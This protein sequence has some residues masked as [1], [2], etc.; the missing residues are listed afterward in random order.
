MERVT[1]KSGGRNS[2]G[3]KVY[4]DDPN[5]VTAR[6]EFGCYCWM[7]QVSLPGVSQHQ[8]HTTATA[9]TTNSPV[10]PPQ[11]PG[12]DPGFGANDDF[13]TLADDTEMHTPMP[14]DKVATTTDADTLVEPVTTS[15]D[16]L[17][18][19][20]RL[21]FCELHCITD[22]DLAQALFYDSPIT[23][24]A[25][26]GGMATNV[27]DRVLCASEQLIDLIRALCTTRPVP[28]ASSSQY[29]GP[30]LE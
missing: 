20:Y 22:R 9:I 16:Q 8:I 18:Q 12:S 4:V 26:T 27:I 21:L 2:P 13:I 30:N 29:S 15:R 14:T 23:P 11:H 17:L 3:K 24:R 1:G 5:I 19:I 7:E 28:S 25:S 6:L 10:A